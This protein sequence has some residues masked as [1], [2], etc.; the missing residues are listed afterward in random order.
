MNWR[1]WIAAALF[2]FGLVSA[3]AP[4]SHAATVQFTAAAQAKWDKLLAVTEKTEAAKLQAAYNGFLSLQ[5]QTDSWD[6]RINALHY[7]NDEAVKVVKSQIKQINASQLGKL[8]A[9]LKQAE[10]KHDPL[11]SRYSSLNKQISAANAMK[12][13]ELKKLLQTQANLLKPLVQLAR[14]DIKAKRDA[15]KS[16]KDSTG[17]KAKQIRAVLAE[18][19]PVKVR[20]QAEK[21]A[22]GAPKSSVSTVMKSLNAAVKTGSAKDARS[23]LAGLNSLQQQIVNRKEKIYGYEEQIA[24]VIARAKLRLAA[25]A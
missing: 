8:E 25:S 6:A 12:S 13:K 10:T 5:K 23:A 1:K 15:L 21:K 24:N 18:I 7:S 3:F 22:I 16:L 2:V 11:L 14:E 19:D 17:K 20:I 9:Q 4:L